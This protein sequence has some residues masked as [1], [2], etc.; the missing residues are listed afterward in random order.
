[1]ADNEKLGST[2]PQVLLKN[3]INLDKLVNDRESESLPDRFA[4]LRRTWFGM[5]M[6]F[7]R[8]ITYI[9]GRGEQ[10]VGAIGWQELGKWAT[11]LTVDNR[12]QIVYYNGSWYKYLGELEHVITGDSPENDGGV[13]SAENP[14]GKWSN[15]GDAALRTDLGSSEKGLGG[16]LVNYTRNKLSSSIKTASQMLDAQPIYCY[17]FVD[18]ITDKPDIS[19]PTTWDWTPAINAAI[20]KSKAMQYQPV[21]LPHHAFITSGGHIPSTNILEYS[22]GST[23]DGKKYKGVP[24]IGYG[25]EISKAKF[26]AA[27]NVSCFSVVGLS[28]GSKS[29][30][31]FRDFTIEP[32][33]TA[34]QYL[35][36]GI[37][38][39]SVGYVNISNVAVYFLDENFRFYNGIA[40][41]WTEFNILNNCFS[42]RGNSCYSFIRGA[43]NDSF[44][45]NHLIGCFGQI[46]TSGGGGYGLKLRGLSSSA[47]VWL[48][49]ADMGIKWY[50]GT[51]AKVIS[52]AFAEMTN[53]TQDMTCEGAAIMESLDDYSRCQHRGRWLN[54]GTTTFSLVS[55]R[56]GAQGRFTFQNLH[57]RTGAFVDSNISDYAPGIM[58]VTP[59]I[60]NNNGV[61]LFYMF[62]TNFAS[63]MQTCQNYA[64]N[65]FYLGQIPLNGSVTDVTPSWKWSNDGGIM[66]SYNVAGMRFQIGSAE[67]VRLTSAAIYPFNDNGMTM[68]LAANRYS[69]SY[70]SRRMYTAITG[71]LFGNGSPEGSVTAGVGS[72]YR[73]L[74]GGASSSF[75]VKETGTGNTGWIAK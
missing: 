31:Y 9:T 61:G 19:D 59:D 17:E 60:Y 54:N 34:Y 64:G 35:G 50:A 26:K 43:G 58:P 51:N 48:Y 11:G 38:L 30:C 27:A 18:V 56:V 24:I 4:V 70:V 33:G 8:F 7:N 66:K 65:G 71:D 23:T 21:C 5:E 63:P 20:A 44:H 14:T 10:A 25:A 16:W 12:Q 67:T 45:G 15:I 22:G 36:Y 41:G 52:L 74:D 73:R 72:T 3:A 57:S 37:E 40:N 53:N 75:Y 32:A 13:W 39:N 1:M 49:E 42:Y 2:S 55:E 47:L 6:V 28:G 69:N 68:G 29:T 46:R 62:G